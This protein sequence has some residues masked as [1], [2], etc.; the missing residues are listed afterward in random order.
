MG[1]RVSASSLGIGGLPKASGKAKVMR[2]TMARARQRV[3]IN[4]RNALAGNKFGK[5]KIAPMTNM[6]VAKARSQGGFKKK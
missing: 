3:N 6:I 1:S 2:R 4:R 5:A